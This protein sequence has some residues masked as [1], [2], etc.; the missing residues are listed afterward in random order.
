MVRKIKVVGISPSP[1]LIT[2]RA[3]EEIRRAKVVV[4]LE[5]DLPFSLENLLR[6]K[7]VVYLEPAYDKPPEEKKKVYERNWARLNEIDED[8]VVW[9][10]VGDPS[11]RNPIE[12]HTLGNLGNLE[13]E[14]VPGVSSVTAVLD[15]LGVI[16][17]HLCV[18]GGEELERIEKALEACDLFVIIN[19]KDGRALDFLKSKGYDVTLV[20]NCCT[21]NERVVKDFGEVRTYWVIAVA[22][23]YDKSSF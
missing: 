22:K 21:D 3:L 6:G 12:R 4:L 2:C 8:E 11:I 7:R 23:R 5:R 17:K 15:R 10:E 19:V 14:F 13:V 16:A 9:L 18:F 20:E 1:S